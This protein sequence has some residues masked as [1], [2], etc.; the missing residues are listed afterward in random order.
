[1]DA[2]IA[3]WVQGCDKYNIKITAM[4][5]LSRVAEFR[6]MQAA[7]PVQADGTPRIPFS[8]E[9]F[10]DA[11]VEWIVSDDQVCFMRMFWILSHYFSH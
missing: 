11:L 10:L 2:H 8:K 3:D 1:M 7:Q 9:G 6:A 4:A 5:A